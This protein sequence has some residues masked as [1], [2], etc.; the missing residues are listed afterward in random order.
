MSDSTREFTLITYFMLEV[1]NVHLHL[2]FSRSSYV[3]THLVLPQGVF[4]NCADQFQGRSHRQFVDFHIS[5][6][7]L[8]HDALKTKKVKSDGVGSVLPKF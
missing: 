5:V 2:L 3:I 7:V 8:E 6:N 4:S 1:H